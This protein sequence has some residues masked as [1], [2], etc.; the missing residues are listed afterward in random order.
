VHA[1]NRW[2]FLRVRL[3]GEFHEPDGT[4]DGHRFSIGILVPNPIIFVFEGPAA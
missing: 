2:E 1:A 3:S 4:A